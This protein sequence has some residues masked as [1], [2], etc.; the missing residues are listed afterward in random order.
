VR[1]SQKYLTTSP[2]FIALIIRLL[3]GR[4]KKGSKGVPNGDDDDDG[5]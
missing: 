4:V 5:N 3:T 1:R 2:P